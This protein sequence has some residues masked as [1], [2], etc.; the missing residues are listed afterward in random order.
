ME[1]NE[2]MKSILTIFTFQI[3]YHEFTNQFLPAISA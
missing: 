2:K 3:F 1:P